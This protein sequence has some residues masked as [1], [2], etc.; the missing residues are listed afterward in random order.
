MRRR[1]DAQP[2]VTRTREPRL[3]SLRCVEAHEGVHVDTGM[4]GGA[5]HHDPDG[6]RPRFGQL[7]AKASRRRDVVAAY[8]L[9]VARLTPSTQTCADPRVVPTAVTHATELPENR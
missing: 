9:T 3:A 6:A 2:G 4:A 1:R 5:D 7:V 8:V